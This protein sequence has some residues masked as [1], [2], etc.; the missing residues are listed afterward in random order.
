[1]VVLIDD[2]SNNSISVD[3][4]RELP[5]AITVLD[6]WIVCADFQNQ[7]LSII[8]F[9][10]LA[11]LSVALIIFT[12]TVCLTRFACSSC[13]AK[14]Y[15]V[16]PPKTSR[17]VCLLI[18]FIA[19]WLMILVSFA[20]FTY[21][22]VNLDRTRVQSARLIFNEIFNDNLRTSRTERDL[23]SAKDSTSVVRE[24]I[25]HS[26]TSVSPNDQADIVNKKAF[27]AFEV[28]T[29]RETP[30]YAANLAIL[31]TVGI[32]IITFLFVSLIT[33]LTG[34]FCY[35]WNYHP[36]DRSELS[37]RI[38]V[39]TV[40]LFVALLFLAPLLVLLADVTFAYAQMHYQLCPKTRRNMVIERVEVFLN[41]IHSSVERRRMANVIET[42]INGELQQLIKNECL[43]SARNI[44]IVWMSELVMGIVA[45]PCSMILMCISKY[46]LRMK[47]EYYWDIN[48]HYSTLTEVR[49]EQRN[50]VTISSTV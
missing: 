20:A 48:D 7:S 33:V 38:G 45:A 36:L 17:F 37:H 35:A 21:N 9:C 16:H 27:E 8:I 19:C 13:G 30:I 1:M 15:Q 12:F 34:T 11:V 40:R 32:L 5:F 25:D 2:R 42:N 10:V 49:D 47:T 28:N 31:I 41:G 4:F 3:I 22:S 39:W 23:T 29:M 18:V 44:N 26:T 24:Y 43:R 46:F 50:V 6:D 14:L